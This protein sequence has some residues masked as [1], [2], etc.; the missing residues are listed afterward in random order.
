[1]AIP[2][3]TDTLMRRIVAGLQVA[4]VVAGSIVLAPRRSRL[5]ETIRE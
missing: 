4:F 5:L 1:M 2:G 3:L